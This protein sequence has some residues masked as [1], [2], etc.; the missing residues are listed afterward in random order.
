MKKERVD[1][2]LVRGKKPQV[3]IELKGN[4]GKFQ[5]QAKVIYKEPRGH[6]DKLGMSLPSDAFNLDMKI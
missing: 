3:G 4:I 6:R 1:G 5:K 2:E